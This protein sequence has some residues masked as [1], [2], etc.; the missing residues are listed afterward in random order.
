M[1][2]V[3]SL[4]DY[5]GDV[6]DCFVTLAMTRCD[7]IQR[8][9][10]TDSTMVAVAQMVEP[11]VVVRVV[12]GSSPVSHPT[13][14][15]RPIGR[16]LYV[17]WLKRVPCGTRGRARRAESCAT[18]EGSKHRRSAH[19]EHSGG[20]SSGTYERSELVT[21]GRV[22][23]CVDPACR[24]RARRAESCATTGGSTHRR[25]GVESA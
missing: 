20:P 18:T 1:T 23:S 14:K 11:S 15:T 8:T 2:G 16:V 12:A 22:L 7:R 21:A 3:T 19:A 6:L 5:C 24:G 17:G 25:A 13:Y 10:E 4:C 9:A